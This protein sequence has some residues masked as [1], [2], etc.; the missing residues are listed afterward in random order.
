MSSV[1]QTFDG[2]FTPKSNIKSFRPEKSTI[3][4][5]PSRPPSTLKVTYFYFTKYY[6]H[7]YNNRPHFLGHDYR[8]TSVFL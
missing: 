2:G 8:C 6:R 7:F 3:L 1:H 4:V 5:D